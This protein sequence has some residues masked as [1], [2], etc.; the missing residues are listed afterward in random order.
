MHLDVVADALGP[1]GEGQR[2]EG[3]LRVQGAAGAGHDQGRL[4]V[5]AQCFL[6]SFWVE[7]DGAFGSCL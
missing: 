4:E 3:L 7:A 2:R 5:P 1:R 6:R